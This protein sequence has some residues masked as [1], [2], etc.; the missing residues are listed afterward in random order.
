MVSVDYSKQLY[1][2]LWVGE[3]CFFW[4]NDHYWEKIPKA[5]KCIDLWH[6]ENL[7]YNLVRREEDKRKRLVP[8]AFL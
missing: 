6:A 8:L 7:A 3:Y 4:M 5:T 2:Q 1:G